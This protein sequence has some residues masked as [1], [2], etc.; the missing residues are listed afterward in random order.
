MSVKLASLNL[1]T[2]ATIISFYGR[3]NLCQG[4][5]AFGATDSFQKFFCLAL[6]QSQCSHGFNV[7][8][9]KTHPSS[10]TVFITK[11]SF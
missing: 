9:V 2:G 7:L 3:Y 11:S 6:D 1:Y 4:A 10:L 8:H 5:S